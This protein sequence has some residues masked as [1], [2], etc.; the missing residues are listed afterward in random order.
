VL[1]GMPGWTRER[2]EQAMDGAAAPQT[3]HVAAP[4]RVLIAYGTGLVKDGR[5]HFFDDLYGQDA[6]LDA[7]LR[8]V[9]QQRRSDKLF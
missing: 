6:V 9:A 3:L 4:L 5:L 2:I 7:A 1:H 8:H